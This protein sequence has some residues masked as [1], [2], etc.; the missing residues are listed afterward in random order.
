MCLRVCVSACVCVSVC[1]CVYVCAY[2]HVAYVL[3][4]M[5][6]LGREEYFTMKYFTYTVRVQPVK[7]SSQP[8]LKKE[9]CQKLLLQY[10]P[11][12]VQNTKITQRLFIK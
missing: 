10:M 2:V 8:D 11:E 7:F 4:Y 1:V 6:V 9:E 3:V 5:C 12:H